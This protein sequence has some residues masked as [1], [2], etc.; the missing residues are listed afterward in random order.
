MVNLHTVSS[1]TVSSIVDVSE[2]FTK[3]SEQNSLKPPS[4]THFVNEKSP[5]HM[6]SETTASFENSIYLKVTWFPLSQFNSIFRNEL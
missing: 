4:R 3:F 5:E 6:L 2:N 1:V